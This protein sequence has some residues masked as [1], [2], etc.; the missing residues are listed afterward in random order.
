MAEVIYAEY[1]QSRQ[2]KAFRLKAIRYHGK[3]CMMCGIKEVPYFH[4]HHLTYERL[5]CEKIKD[6]VVLCEVCHN[7]VHKTGFVIKPNVKKKK[8][9]RAFNRIRKDNVKT[10][11]EKED[12]L[13]WFQ[14]SVSDD[15]VERKKLS[16]GK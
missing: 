5:G 12:L 3:S 6:V 1:L 14:K 16:T 4:V 11:K 10:K 15:Y 9:A 13:A 8:Q 2:W 7:E